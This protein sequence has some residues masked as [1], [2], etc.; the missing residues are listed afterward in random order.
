[1][2]VERETIELAF[3][4]ALQV[5]PPQQRAALI[6]RDVLGWPASETA[7]VARDERRRGEQR[8]AT[9]AGD[10]AGPPSGAPR[11]LVG[12]RTERARSAR[13]SPG[14]STRTN[15]ATPRQRSPIASEDIRITM[16]PYPHRFEGIPGSTELLGAR[17]RRRAR[18]ATGG[19]CRQRPTGCPPRR[20][21]CAAPG[22]TE[23]RAVQ[24][25]RAAHRRR[26]GRRDHDVRG[27][28]D[29]RVRPAAAAR[30]TASTQ[31]ASRGRNTMPV[32][33]LGQKNVVFCGMRAPASAAARVWRPKP[34]SRESLRSRRPCRPTPRPPPRRGGSARS[35]RADGARRPRPTT[36]A[37][38]SATAGCSPASAA[39][40]TSAGG[41]R[42]RGPARRRGRA[43]A[44]ERICATRSSTASGVTGPVG[45]ISNASASAR[46]GRYPRAGRSAG[47]SARCTTRRR[48]ARRR[49]S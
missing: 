36:A 37:S 8:A 20:A 48:R 35:R 26:Q 1:M 32:R 11:R 47:G 28:S 43:R 25:R 44:R 33:G 42:A 29:R 16:P 13:C 6:A 10:D 9:G 39:A 30:L 5:L 49:T 12:T 46:A 24:A 23:F 41:R 22:D 38:V 34:A 2:V 21:T 15:A 18:Q 7:D 19:W 31:S 14:S 4:A 17:V 27:Q 45:V 3:L 40:R